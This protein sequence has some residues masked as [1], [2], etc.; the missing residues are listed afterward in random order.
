MNAAGDITGATLPL[1][2]GLKDIEFARTARPK[3]IAAA[4]LKQYEGAYALSPEHEAKFYVKGETLYAFIEGQPEYELVPTG[5]HSF[6]IK[7]LSGYKVSFVSVNGE[8][9][10]V[11]FNQ[12]NGV[13]RAEKKK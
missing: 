3:K 13:F 4:D 12:P 1:Q 7:A 5:N 8:T 9:T 11:Y 6:E 10:A 2:P